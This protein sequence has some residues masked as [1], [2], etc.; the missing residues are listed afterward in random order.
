MP[1]AKPFTVSQL[2]A[3]QSFTVLEVELVSKGEPKA[4]FS[5]RG[6]GSL[7]NAAVKDETG[8]VQLTLWNE[9]V[10][11]YHEGDQ[12]KIENGWCSEYKGRKQISTG[13]NGT[14]TVLS[15]KPAG[16]KEEE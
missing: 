11:Q 14:I 8:E 3:N 5:Q 1:T 6:N 16:A 4:F 9:Q 12:L 2:V 15:S 10:K 13:R 7:C